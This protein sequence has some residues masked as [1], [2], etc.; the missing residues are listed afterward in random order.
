MVIHVNLRVFDITL[1]V[2]SVKDIHY[3]YLYLE[4]LFLI[5]SQIK[6]SV[7]E[8]D[9]SKKQKNINITI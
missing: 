6:N 3:S 8:Y 1:Q 4:R 7:I 2:K 5:D 9:F